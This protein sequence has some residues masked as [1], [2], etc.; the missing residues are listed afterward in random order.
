MRAKFQIRMKTPSSAEFASLVEQFETRYRTLGHMYRKVLET[1]EQKDVWNSDTD[2]NERIMFPYFL[3][4]GNMSRVLGFK[5]CEI[6]GNQLKQLD[7]RLACFKQN[8]L[9][10]V[11][12]TRMSSEITDLYKIILNA[13]WT[14]KK[15]KLKRV[16]PTSTAKALHLVAPNLFMIWDQ[17][18]RQYYGFK[19]TGEAYT[20]FLT[21]MQR[22]L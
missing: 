2:R 3:K 5:G 7:A 19:D 13:T 16:G 9:A 14:S 11:D 4:W 10:T 21:T 1:C 8:T 6:L 17:A 20:R 22:W 18:I 15:G 12:L